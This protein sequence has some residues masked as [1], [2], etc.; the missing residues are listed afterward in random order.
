MAGKLKR[1]ADDIATPV[2]TLYGLKEDR[3]TGE[4]MVGT[5]H[6]VTVYD[7][8]L[9]E[10]VILSHGIAFVGQPPALALNVTGGVATVVLSQGIAGAHYRMEYRNSLSAGDTWTLLQDI[11]SLVGTTASVPD[12]TPIANRT[13]RYYRALLVR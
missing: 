6:R 10:S 2:N 7:D 3:P 4:P 5:I 1:I 11:P 13:H 8:L 12:S 9:Q